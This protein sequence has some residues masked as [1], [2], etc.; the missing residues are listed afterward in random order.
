MK[1]KGLLMAVV[2]IPL[3]FSGC[4]RDDLIAKLVSPSAMQEQ[5]DVAVM[6]VEQFIQ[7]YPTAA[8]TDSM[9]SWR[10]LS[11]SEDLRDAYAE[12]S[13]PNWRG[14]MNDE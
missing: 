4:N 3:L 8:G 7:I 12:R 2:V 14:E 6:S 9:L 13:H 1:S 10:D 5:D 11:Y